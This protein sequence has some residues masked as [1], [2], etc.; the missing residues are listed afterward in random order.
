MNIKKN[1]SKKYP[2]Y[3]TTVSFTLRRLVIVGPKN[4]QNNAKLICL[5][6]PPSQCPLHPFKMSLLKQQTQFNPTN[7]DLGLTGSL[8]ATKSILTYNL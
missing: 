7:W 4:I 3:F 2:V 6:H 8:W 1:I 5:T